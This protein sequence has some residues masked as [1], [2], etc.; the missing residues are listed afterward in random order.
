MCYTTA[1]KSSLGKSLTR[2]SSCEPVGE[3]STHLGCKIQSRH[4][5]TEL[6]ALSLQLV[7]IQQHGAVQATVV[8]SSRQHKAGL[9]G[10]RQGVP[11][12]TI[13]VQLLQGSPLPSEHTR[14]LFHE[15]ESMS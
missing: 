15:R 9:V 3:R 11:V 8:V 13:V 14:G 5:G 1:G 6:D 10:T 2:T 12:D 4:A 7:F